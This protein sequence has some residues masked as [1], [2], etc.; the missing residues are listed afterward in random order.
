MSWPLRVAAFVDSASSRETTDW[1]E[2]ARHFLPRRGVGTPSAFSSSAIASSVQPAVR[3][4]KIPAVTT[5]VMVEGLPSL[6]P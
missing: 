5:S 2:L 3:L 1:M 4:R 6:T